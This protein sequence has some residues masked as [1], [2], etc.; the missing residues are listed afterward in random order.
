MRKM[1]GQWSGVKCRRLFGILLSICMIFIVAASFA[2]ASGGG[3]AAGEHAPSLFKAYLWPVVNFLAL[4]LLVVFMMKKMDIKGYFQ[5]RTELIEQTLK[6]A[7]EAKALAEKALA[8]VEERLKV[9]DKEIAEIVAYAR[10]SGESEK[11]RLVAEGEGMQAKILEQTKNNID[12]EIKRAK[13][14]IKEEAVVIAM[15]LAEKKIREKM[16]KDE[17]VRLLE[18]SLAKIEGK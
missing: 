1:Q 9:K 5:K 7:K 14:A 13:E 3:A 2:A 10:Q 16:T 4:V 11:T 6:E 15:E 17:Q 12:Y 18:E 8:E